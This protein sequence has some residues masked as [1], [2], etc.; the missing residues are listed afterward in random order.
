MRGLAGWLDAETMRLMGLALLHFLWQGVAIAAAAFMGMSLVRRA[1]AKYVVAVA[2]LALMVAAPAVTYL[3]LAKGRE[4]AS[5]SG[6][7][8]PARTATSPRIAPAVP[9]AA[10]ATYFSAAVE[11]DRASS[12]YLLW[13]V[14]AWF[15][16]VVLLSLRPAA[17]FFLIGRLRLK[18][19]APSAARCG[20]AAWNCNGGWD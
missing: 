17:G 4:A 3:V 18:K 12:I 20:R 6:K 5:V 15:V 9:A 10:N 2:M 7:E 19:G 16:G 1:S 13:F 8:V 14:E 11:A